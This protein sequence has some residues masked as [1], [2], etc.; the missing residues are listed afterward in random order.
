MQPL[1]VVNGSI[2]AAQRHAEQTIQKDLLDLAHESGTRM[3][4]L[5]RR[6]L[7]LVGYPILGN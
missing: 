2:E 4:S 5:M 7:T 6:L 1:T 3:Q